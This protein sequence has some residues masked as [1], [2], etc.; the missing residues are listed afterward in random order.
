LQQFFY[1]NPQVTVAH[2]EEGYRLLNKSIIRVEQ[3]DVAFDG[4]EEE[5]GAVGDE[6]DEMNTSQQDQ[7]MDEDGIAGIESM[8]ADHIET[9]SHVDSH[10]VPGSQSQHKKKKLKLSYEEYKSMSTLLLL[11]M[12]RQESRDEESGEDTEGLKRSHVVDWYLNEIGDTIDTED[13]LIEKKELVE[14]VIDRLIHH[15]SC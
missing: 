8:A 12:R 6:D 7:S 2:V 1:L 14:K 4:D 3:P 15:V 9:D 10:S 5:P 13:E 11:Y